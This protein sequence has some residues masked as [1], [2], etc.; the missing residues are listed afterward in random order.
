MSHDTLSPGA[1]H[2]SGNRRVTLVHS[3][4]T[5]HEALDHFQPLFDAAGA[6]ITFVPFDAS[7]GQVTP[8]LVAA[9]RDTG[10]ALMGYQWG[11]RDENSFPPIA[12]LRQA[13]GI[14]TNLR[15]I[16]SLAGLGALWQDLDLWIVREVT[17]DV[18]AHLEHETL[19]G[20]YEGL[21]VTTRAACERIARQAFEFARER[22]RK[23]VTTVHKA[24]ILKLADGMF[25]RVSK[26]VAAEYPDIEHDDVIIDACCMKLVQAPQQYDV[27]LCGNLFGNILGD[28]GAGLV[29]GPVNSPSI[30]VGPDA[31]IFT[32]GQRGPKTAHADPL[33]ILISSLYMLEKLGRYPARERLGRAMEEAVLAGV[34]PRVMGGEADCS[35]Y[36]QAVRERL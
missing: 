11:M 10:M 21:K 19:P 27:L 14:H 8:E 34:L 33:P 12:Q 30:N 9:I 25:L 23:R 24:N 7:D 4:S 35:V 28:L 3:D 18:Y 1:S 13:L 17:E 5:G 20:I 31:T 26:E 29:G 16:R 36:V 32:I 15:P 6:D 2:V 22:G